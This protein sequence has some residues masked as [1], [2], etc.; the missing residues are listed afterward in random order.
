MYMALKK[1][2]HDGR[3]YRE[4]ELINLSKVEAKP[5]IKG[6][7]VELY[8]EPSDEDDSYEDD[9]QGGAGGNG[10]EGENQNS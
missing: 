3:L 10:A 2:I 4:G 5:M 9:E 8:E 1:V 6:G 7:L